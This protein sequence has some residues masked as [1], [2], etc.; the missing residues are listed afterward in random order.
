MRTE[1][2]IRQMDQAIERTLVSHAENLKKSIES[3][4]CLKCRTS[5]ETLLLDRAIRF[6]CCDYVCG[7]SA[8]YPIRTLGNSE[9]AERDGTLDLVAIAEREVLEK[10]KA[11]TAVWRSL[12]GEAKIESSYDALESL[13]ASVTLLESRESL[14]I[15]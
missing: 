15:G 10:A 14:R 3:G 9:R 1:H 6:Q 4:Q 5:I 8:I 7:W 11:L 2:E 13:L 12:Q